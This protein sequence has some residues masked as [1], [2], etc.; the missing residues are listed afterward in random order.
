MAA[1]NPTEKLP[2]LT[3]AERRRYSRHLLLPE[4]GVEGQ[5]RLK[6]SSALVVGA[7]GLGSPALLYLAAAGVGRI[8][9]VDFDEVDESNLQRQVLHATP[10]LG[11][12]KTESARRR[13]IGLNPEI[14]LE[15]HA[16]RLDASNVMR[17]GGGYDVVLDGS[18]NF[19]TRY[20]LNDAC[21]LLGIPDVHG[22]VFRFE[23]LLSVFATRGGPCYRCLHPEPP[24]PGLV[25]DCATGGVLGVLPGVIGTLQATEALKILLGLG[26]TLA[27]R[28]LMYQALPMR[29][30]ELR[31]ARDPACAACGDHPT[32]REPK[33]L[34]ASCTSPIPKTPMREIHPTDLKR[35]LDSP[36]PPFLLDV[37]EPREHDLCRI[38]GGTL[39]PLGQLPGRIGE[40]DPN[41][42]IVV[43]CRSGGRSGNATLFLMQNG[44][45][46]V[47]NLAG[48]ILAWSDH[49]DPSVPKY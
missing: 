28:L 27:G 21:V 4:I 15:L 5:R 22:S 2:E 3:D 48:G 41:D 6:A 20:L 13:L 9:I 45:R 35:E 36:K 8:G 49:V 17:I 14:R 24:P 32:I 11:T 29:F 18:D 38:P 26:P 43:Y 16:E 7:G 34:A 12:A 46:R 10:D 23:G 31:L 37:R 33:D 47:R 44:F 19:A 1:H 30:R 39:I 40:L 25:P 42:D